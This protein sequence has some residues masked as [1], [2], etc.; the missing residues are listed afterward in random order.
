MKK[1]AAGFGRESRATKTRRK[2][3]LLD[4]TGIGK[5]DTIFCRCVS[6]VEKPGH[7]SSR[8]TG[9][10]AGARRFQAGSL[11]RV[12]R[13]APSNAPFDRRDRRF[14]S[15]SRVD[16]GHLQIA[17]KPVNLSRLVN[18]WLDDL[19]ALPDSPEVKIEE[20]ISGRFIYRRRKT[21]YLPHCAKS[22]RERTKVQSA[23]RP[24]PGERITGD[25]QKVVLT[26][27]TTLATQ[28]RRRKYLRAVSSLLDSLSCLRP[29][30]WLKFGTRARP[31][32]WRQ[33]TPGAIGKR[34]DRIR[35]A[36]FRRKRC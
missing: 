28:F 23:G 4:S 35:S 8:R 12:I 36:L 24:N 18:E 22:P 10:I 21:I 13:L 2:R 1:L 34:L 15:L 17:S 9:N 7:R 25:G 11:R 20:G 26:V 14:A 16:A 19:G 27:G 33:I 29:R 32:A 31:I 6:P 30:D 5:I 3:A